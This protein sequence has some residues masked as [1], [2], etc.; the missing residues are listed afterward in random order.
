M[1]PEQCEG[2]ARVDG[3]SDLYALG[4]VLYEL[5]TNAPPFE[6]KTLSEAVTTH[7]RGVMP[8]P[9]SDY[10]P[11][12]P[13]ILDELL[14]KALSKRPEERFA[15]GEAMALVL[16]G[17]QLAFAGKETKVFTPEV[18]A[19]Q[20]RLPEGFHLLIT[21]PGTTP[22]RISLTRRVIS[23]GRSGDN[24][25][26]LPTD[27][28]SRYHAR[29]QAAESGWAVIDL[30]GVNGT[31]MDGDRLPVNQIVPL[32]PGDEI[33]VG[34]YS[35]KLEAPSGVPVPAPT[36]AAQTPTGLETRPAAERPTEIMPPEVLA[37]F[38]PQD[39]ISVE[40]GQ[41]VTVHLEVANRGGSPDRVN[42]RVQGLPPGW[43]TL[44]EEFVSVPPGE[45]AQL[46]LTIMPPRRSDTP[47][48]RQRFQARVIS[49]QHPASTATV[50]GTLLIG[51]F[52]AF[53]A[54][55]ESRQVRLPGSV[56]V[57]IS[58]TGNAA[59]DFSVVGRDVGE[60]LQF[61]GETGHVPLESGQT[62]LVELA[63][64][65]GSTGLFGR[66]EPVDFEIE[67]AAR[68]G[69]RQRLA[70]RAIV[71]PVVP[72]FLVYA[73]IVVL[74]FGC[75]FGASYLLFGDQLRR[76]EPAPTQPAVAIAT[77]TLPSFT[78]VPTN[79]AT[80]T[81][82]QATAVV[83]TVT[84]GA[85]S[86]GATGDIDQDGLSGSQEAIART[87]PNRPD[88][89][90]DGLIDG[91]EVLDLGTDPLKRDTDGDLLSDGDEVTMFLTDPRRADT[92]GD[93][94]RDGVEV[95]QGT[96]PLATPEPIGGTATATLSTPATATATTT[97]SLTATPAGTA[98]TTLTSTPGPSSTPTATSVATPTTTPTAAPTQTATPPATAT[99]T[100]T[101][102]A[103]PLPA[104]DLVC[105]SEPPSVDG[106]VFSGEWEGGPLFDAS[107]AGAP[108]RVVELYMARSA[109]NLY[110]AALVVDETPDI[111]D[112]IRIYIDTTGNGGDP[113]MTDRFFQI[114]RD[115]SLIIRAG[116]G[117]NTDGELWDSAYSSGNWRAAVINTANTGWSMEMVVE[118]NAEMPALNP[119]GFPFLAQVLFTDEG[120][121]SLPPAASSTNAGTWQPVTNTT[122]P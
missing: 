2:E 72:S 7:L 75:I 29:L 23:L 113:D 45:S 10:R 119:V 116:L 25:I 80:A 59:T 63:L 83:A 49:Q 30:G 21:A 14:Q 5:V 115:E 90:G 18:I 69:G 48:G 114:G 52:H 96:D 111:T 92:D 32:S 68:Q 51:A 42:L 6:F 17:A 9:A 112:S 89:D 110:L 97:P 103:T 64:R 43:V 95:D 121:L 81:A 4:A 53:Q 28:V 108:G 93:G 50:T 98:T 54:E 15:T 19:G 12:I 70:G 117:T 102:T 61:R 35:L 37:L 122:C 47:V 56:N 33:G 38:L 46:A 34:P 99:S 27:G 76:G 44:P 60:R 31:F 78:G 8:R 107:L 24:D 106:V 11:D 101:P 20:P 94:V 84:A 66:E 39:R 13:S 40:P 22:S 3:R 58:N 100:S 105:L 85:G 71:T 36:P 87:D 16:R 91:R 88:T 104:P 79:S 26:V 74:T 120:L 77:S 65:A 67:V 73:A 118:L 55:L 82:A 86:G 57:R 1:A 109:N 62:A 41:P